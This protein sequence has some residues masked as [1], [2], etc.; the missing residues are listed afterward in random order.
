MKKFW[1]WLF[2]KIKINNANTKA[3]EEIEERKKTIEP[4][5][6]DIKKTMDD[7]MSKQPDGTPNWKPNHGGGF[8]PWL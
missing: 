5:I 1:N 6:E 2:G 3:R 8:N 4:V 7:F